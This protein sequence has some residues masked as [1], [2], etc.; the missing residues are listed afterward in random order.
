MCHFHVALRHFLLSRRQPFLWWLLIQKIRHL[1][2]CSFRRRRIWCAAFMSRIYSCML[3]SRAFSWCMNTPLFSPAYQLSFD[4]NTPPLSR[5]TFSISSIFIEISFLRRLSL[6][7]HQYRYWQVFTFHFFDTFRRRQPAKSLIFFWIALLQSY[8]SLSFF[9]QGRLLAFRL[10]SL[11]LY[12]TVF[13]HFCLVG[14]PLQ[15]SGF[16]QATG[17]YRLQWGWEP[18]LSAAWASLTWCFS[19]C[20]SEKADFSFLPHTERL[21]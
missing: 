5:D 3:R 11:S 16:C 1:A 7:Y 8:I 17:D 21:E 15:I 12:C 2:A 20:M 18:F 4:D 13:S 19:A 6:H 9:R 14:M 10:S